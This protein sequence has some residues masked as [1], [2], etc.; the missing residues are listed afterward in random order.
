MENISPSSKVIKCDYCDNDCDISDGEENSCFTC[1]N[2]IDN[3]SISTDNCLDY[4]ST[5]DL[6]EELKKRGMLTNT[7]SKIDIN[8][9]KGMIMHKGPNPH[10]QECRDCRQMRSSDYFSFYQQRVDKYGYLQRS[11]A[12][13]KD[14]KKKNEKQRKICLDKATKKGQIPEKPKPGDKCP[15]CKRSWG[16]NKK[17]RNWHRHHI[18]D[19]FIS[20]LCGDCN[21]SLHDQRHKNINKI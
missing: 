6:I 20:W 14:C 5:I 13:C 8:Q 7:N 1:Q 11:N 18:D 2:K 15:Q 3:N 4:V 21:M 10:K 9:V 17:P 16:T 12:L 19:D